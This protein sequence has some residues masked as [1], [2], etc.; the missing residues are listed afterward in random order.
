ME[1]VL[2]AEA[3][4]PRGLLGSNT[5]HLSQPRLEHMDI[6]VEAHKESVAERL[7]ILHTQGETPVPT[8][9]VEPH[10]EV[11]GYTATAPDTD[12]SSLSF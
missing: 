12:S 7:L 6:D 1:Q 5:V 11:L 9:A 8:V 2:G 3:E 4:E 10:L